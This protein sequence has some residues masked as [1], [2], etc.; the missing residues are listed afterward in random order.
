MENCNVAPVDN[1]PKAFSYVVEERKMCL[2]ISGIYLS[3]CFVSMS[4]KLEVSKIN[5]GPKTESPENVEY[6]HLFWYL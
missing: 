6:I 2:S 3:P 4:K 1:R 5:G